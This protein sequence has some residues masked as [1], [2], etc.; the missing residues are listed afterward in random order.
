MAADTVVIKF[1]EEGA[2][3]IAAAIKQIGTSSKTAASGAKSLETAG[4]A[5]S[6]SLEDMGLEIEDLDK[7][8]DELQDA[9]SDAEDGLDDLAR[10]SKKSE[11]TSKSLGNS[12]KGLG[13]N[14]LLL[15]SAI[16]SVGRL[17]SGLARSFSEL[18]TGVID[19]GGV[20][21]DIRGTLGALAAEGKNT[22]GALSVLR[23]ATQGQVRDSQLQLGIIKALG[24]QFKISAGDL[25]TLTEAVFLISKPTGDFAQN[26]NVL[27]NALRSGTPSTL[28]SIT[29]FDDLQVAIDTA[30]RASAEAGIPFTQIVRQQVGIAL[31]LARAN[32]ITQRFGDVTDSAGDKLQKARVN[33][34][35]FKDEV[36]F[37][38]ATTP[39]LIAVFDGLGEAVGAIARELGDAAGT[40]GE[41]IGATIGEGFAFALEKVTEFLGFFRTD[42]LPVIRSFID[43]FRSGLPAIGEAFSRLAQQAKVRIGVIADIFGLS[44]E[45]VASFAETVG[46][47]VAKFLELAVEF[48]NA[49][50]SFF[51][52]VIEGIG[53][54]A[55]EISE[56]AGITINQFG[57]I[58][59]SA[60]ESL[61]DRLIGLLKGGGKAL[62]EFGRMI[63]EQIGEKIEKFLTLGNQI[64]TVL[65]PSLKLIG[66]GL[67]S[68]V[69]IGLEFLPSL[70][71]QF[72]EL[73]KTLDDT[74]KGF[75]LLR[76]GFEIFEAVT[77]DDEIDKAADETVE[78]VQRRIAEVRRE[79]EIKPRIVPELDEE[80]LQREIDRATVL[81]RQRAARAAGQGLTPAIVASASP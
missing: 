57:E 34:E 52:G 75:G 80:A 65:L 79:F 40:V 74:K 22:A 32:I 68:A 50:S 73:N 39:A 45:N 28:A 54:F 62:R 7:G 9:F 66:E 58:F 21:A 10:A 20:L 67:L 48:T 53:E 71:G 2:K 3:Q 41:Q 13:A 44:S 18:T 4:E 51:T 72:R 70:I 37:N 46:S 12:F 35:N 5:V 26:F 24:G 19:A 55:D 8:L 16:L 17:I 61:G 63:G 43:G 36:L 6:V 42:V 27:I 38:I 30:A 11:N 1:V 29:G 23:R 78:R 59:G 33:L 64:R 69:E 49:A 81:F 15:P 14:L 25:E 76:I 31:A 77:E 56:A 60:D 47:T